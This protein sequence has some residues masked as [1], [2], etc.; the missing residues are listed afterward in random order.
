MVKSK[1]FIFPLPAELRYVDINTVDCFNT[2]VILPNAIVL[3]I[4][5]ASFSKSS[6]TVVSSYFEVP[7]I[8]CN[9][10][11]SKSKFSAPSSSLNCLL[12]ELK[13]FASVVISADVFMSY[14]LSPSAFICLL[15]K[16]KSSPVLSF[17]DS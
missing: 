14:S 5:V 11:L 9:L 17:N 2:C 8:V 6:T 3:D 12:S 7:T 4:F 15:M 1:P 10:F 13:A 16:L